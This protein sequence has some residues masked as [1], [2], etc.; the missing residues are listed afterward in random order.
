MDLDIL[1]KIRERNQNSF[2]LLF[3]LY[4]ERLVVYAQSF[5]PDR[6]SCEDVVQEVFI[7][8]WENSNSI[9]ITISL[10]GYLYKMVKNRMLNHLKTIKNNYNIEVLSYTLEKKSYP[11]LEH[12][13]EEKNLK[14]NVLSQLIDKLP[15]KMQEIFVL[16]YRQ[17]FSYSEIAEYLNVSPNTV[18]TQLKRAKIILQNQLPSYILMFFLNN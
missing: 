6:A 9:N 16:K 18:K 17:N 5:F 15:N 13:Q 11:E 4:Y 7:H 8:L 3:N 12:N 10:K 1:I 2:E 14:L